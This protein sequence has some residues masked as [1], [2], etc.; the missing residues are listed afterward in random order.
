MGRE[1]EFPLLH[2]TSGLSEEA[3]ARGVEE[4]T[5]RRVLHSV[6]E[7]LDFTHDR[8]REVAYGQILAPR[9]KVLHRRV[10]EALETLYAA[11][12]E[13][14]H[15]ALGLHYFEGEVWERAV[16]H[17]RLAGTRAFERSANLDAVA[18]LER[19]LQALGHLPESPFTLEQAFEIRLDLRPVLGQLG[20]AQATL[21][22]L[23]EAE[24]V[25]ERLADDHRRGR[26]CAHLTNTC[27]L[28][29]ELDN[30]LATGARALEI[31]GRIGDL[32][33]R[34]VTTS[35]LAQAHYY[36]GDYERV[37]ELALD[38]LAASPADW[39]YENL[40]TSTPASVRDRHWLIMTLAQ[41]GRFG[42][43]AEH[44]AEAIRLAE[45]TRHAMTIGLPLIASGTLGLIKGN[46]AKAHRL[47][48]HGIAVLRTGNVALLL[49]IAVISFGWVLA[50]LGEG[51]DALER[52]REGQQLLDRLGS[53]AILGWTCHALGSAYMQLGR[54]D[55][56]QRFG[57]RVMDSAPSQFGYAAH[58]F[59]L[60][61]DIR[62][63]PTGSMPTA[64]RPTTARRWLS[65]SRAGC[66][67]SSHIAVSGSASSIDVWTGTSRRTNTSPQPRSCTT[68]WGCR[69]GWDRRRRS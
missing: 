62:P 18:C 17:L 38:N 69:S 22:R 60:L 52:L 11:N 28:L 20:E 14:H 25:A 54:L 59:H 26:V 37:L 49:P 46:W 34:I 64:A 5:N 50:E 40:G 44:E 42:E 23:R 29:G 39:V 43:A 56:A 67:R 32:R 66:G 21:E 27:S 4:L 58:A 31:A 61:G 10:A 30:A 57:K 13:P 33:L 35:H 2:G 12:L 55:E 15:L 63:I 3:V 36:R 41:L 16:V 1:F 47:L 6:G 48:E 19:A 24:A 65:P 45:P 68:T 9:R 53:S 51:G 8:V 7:R